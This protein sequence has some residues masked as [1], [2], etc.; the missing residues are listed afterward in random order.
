MVR[1]CTKMVS[2]TRNGGLGSGVEGRGGHLGGTYSVHSKMRYATA[3][4]DLMKKY[5]RQR[6]ENC[7]GVMLIKCV[8]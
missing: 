8:E 3:R 2:E 7:V 4:N 1:C 6:G 5:L